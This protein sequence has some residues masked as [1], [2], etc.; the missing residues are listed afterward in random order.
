MP[1]TERRQRSA[2]LLHRLANTLKHQFPGAKK[3][4]TF[5]ALP[6]EV[7]LLLLHALLPNHHFHYPLVTKATEMEFHLV[8]DPSSLVEGKFGILEPRPMVNP[9]VIAGDLDLF[10]IPGLAFDLRGNRLGQ[11]G[12]FY[13][14]F[15]TN[16]PHA[17]R[18]GI[19]LASQVLPE[20]AAEPHDQKMQYLLT[21]RSLQKVG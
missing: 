9:P 21:E 7:D 12:G 6:H 20:L 16:T 18:I 2:E 14:R 15:L 10:L 3:I 4:A 8:N 17:I 13:D 19:T 1:D 5:A 11:G